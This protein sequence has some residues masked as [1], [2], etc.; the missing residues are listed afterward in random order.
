M[1]TEEKN[2]LF[3]ILSEKLPSKANEDGDGEGHNTSNERDLE[4]HNNLLNR[5]D[6]LEKENQELTQ[7]NTTLL[8]QFEEVKMQLNQVN[9]NYFDLETKYNDL[10]AETELKN[11]KSNNEYEESVSLSIQ[12]SEIKGKLDARELTIMKLKEEK[13]KT[14]ADFNQKFQNLKAENEMLKEKSM[15]FD[16][17]KEKMDKYDAK[18]EE[19]NNLKSKN[20]QNEKLIKD[21]NEKIKKLNSFVDTDKSK[22]LK[23][24]EELNFKITEDNEKIAE[25]RKE[26]E[27]YKE[28]IINKENELNAFKKQVESYKSNEIFTE[29]EK[30]E[31]NLEKKS[32]LV[33]IEEQNDI[34]KQKLEL[35]TKVKFL[36]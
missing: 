25:F 13:E 8:L 24:I 26:I 5:I 18:I 16:L 21:Q 4:E 34:K 6:T 10:L 28:N 36:W 3:E 31:S 33:E 23:K 30:L 2:I 32:T 15:K 14:S 35:E 9:H 22:L 20:L 12:L 11:E 29:I 17:L 27:I 19:L 1:S 7:S